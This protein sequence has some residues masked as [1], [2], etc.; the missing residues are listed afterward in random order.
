MQIDKWFPALACVA[1]I[2]YVV[3]QRAS[4]KANDDSASRMAV[5][6]GTR[7]V[8][9]ETDDSLKR[10]SIALSRGFTQ[11]EPVVAWWAR[12]FARIGRGFGK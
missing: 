7:R 10:R 8:W 5:F 3:L 4:P 11:V 1:L 2:I 12:L 9:G 6:T